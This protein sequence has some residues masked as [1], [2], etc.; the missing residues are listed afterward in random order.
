MTPTAVA[1]VSF[2]TREPLRACLESVLAEG[3]AET[4]VADNG[5]RD[6]SAEMVRRDFPGVRL[7]VDPANPGFGAAANAAIASTS[8]PY[9]LLLN[10]DVVLRPGAL[11]ALAGHFDRH[12]RAAVAGPRVLRPDGSLQPSCFPFPSPWTALL[13]E[14]HLGYPLRFVPGLRELHLRTWRHDRPR[15]VPWVLGAALALRRSDFVTVGGF[16]PGYFLFFEEVD[17]CWR[18]AAA[19]R[20]T[21]FM[22]AAE[23]VHAGGASTGP[24]R[25]EVRLRYYASMRRFYGRHYPPARRAGLEAVL[26]GVAA[27]AAAGTALRRLSARDPERRARLGEDLAAWRRVLRGRQPETGGQPETDDPPGAAGLPPEAADRLP[28]AS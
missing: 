2:E 25:A 27:A 17:L 11:A 7:L 23:V 28:E 6:G 13:G 26:R 4:V 16:D 21:W 1:V 20:E 12:P 8:A 10:A 22:P 15:T 9:V 19:G 5:S 3:P 14:A 18:L 24:R